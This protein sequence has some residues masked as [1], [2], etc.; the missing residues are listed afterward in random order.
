MA[1]KLGGRPRPCASKVKKNALK[2]TP[3]AV[4]VWIGCEVATCESCLQMTGQIDRNSTVSK[5]KYLHWVKCG[6]PSRKVGGKANPQQLQP[7]GKECYPC[8]FVRR[9]H[10]QI[11]QDDLNQQRKDHKAVDEKYWEIRDDHVSEGG[12]FKKEGQ[13]DMTL[14][15]EKKRGS[16]D[17]RF[18]EG[19]FEPIH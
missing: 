9:K 14:L 12:K 10:F 16:Y 8:F 15:T 4:D 13:L 1:P 7:H 2:K 17:D 5:P 3:V 6:P 11:S 18:V 19:T